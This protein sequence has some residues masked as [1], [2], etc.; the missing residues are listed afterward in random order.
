MRGVKDSPSRKRLVRVS[1]LIHLFMHSVNGSLWHHTASSKRLPQL[2]LATDSWEA[3]VYSQDLQKLKTEKVEE[4][5][6]PQHNSATPNE[7]IAARDPEATSGNPRSKSRETSYSGSARAAEMKA[8][9]EAKALESKI[10]FK[11]DLR[12]QACA[13]AH[14]GM[15]EA[16]GGRRVPLRHDRGSRLRRV[17]QPTWRHDGEAREAGVFLPTWRHEGEARE[18]GVC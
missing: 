14:G 9:A 1:L 10:S 13:P 3:R 12:P 11:K 4:H 18:A 6:N 16:Q 5:R 7:N 17:P 2:N 15:T 8:A